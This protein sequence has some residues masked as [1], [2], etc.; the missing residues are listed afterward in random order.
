MLRGMSAA[1]GRSPRIVVTLAATTRDAEPALV[2]RKNALYVDAVTRHGGTAIPL[3]ATASESMRAGAFASMDGLLLTGG[4]DVE[5]A[6]YGRPEAGSSGVD[7]ARDALEAAAW[8]AAEARA[9]PVLGICRGLQVM[10]AFAGGTLTQ[11]VDGH[12]GAPYGHGE[13]HTHPLRLAAGSR[14]ARILNPTN[15]GASVLTVNSYHHQAVRP[16]DLAPGFVACGFSASPAGELVEALE[17]PSGPFRVAV[18]CH[19]E[20]SESTPKAFERLF[21]FFVDACRGPITDR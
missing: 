7:P 3:D 10:N 13:A 19:P 15:A 9:L 2:A 14:L 20:R 17:A 6:R 5:P 8:A 21:A 1:A 4:S 16:A 12:Q 18:Q 11:H